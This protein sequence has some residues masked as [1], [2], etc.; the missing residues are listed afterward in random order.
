MIGIVF[1]AEH[2]LRVFEDVSIVATG[3]Q[4]ATKKKQGEIIFLFH[5]LILTEERDVA[6]TNERRCP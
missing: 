1:G 5:S 4:N 3:K 2:R 6:M